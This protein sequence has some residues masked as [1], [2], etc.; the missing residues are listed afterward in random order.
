[1]LV[2]FINALLF[3][4]FASFLR[5]YLNVTGIALAISISYTCEVIILFFLLKKRMEITIHLGNTLLRACLAAIAGGIACWL[6]MQLPSVGLNS[7]LLSAGAMLLGLCVSVPF[8]N[9]E[10]RSL[11]KL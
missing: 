4:G 7:L 1:L 5:T 9:K 10:I 11:I 3:I 2:S 6:L 8:I